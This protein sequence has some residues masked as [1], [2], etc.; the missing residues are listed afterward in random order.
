MKNE[1]TQGIN[2]DLTHRELVLEAKI[3]QQTSVT[4]NI[5]E[6]EHVFYHK[7]N[8]HKC[9]RKAK[10]EYS[11]HIR[12]FMIRGTIPNVNSHKFLS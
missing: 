6:I 10:T 11:V 4:R 12:Y 9:S 8:L 7:I 3:K 2:V 5:M 1:M